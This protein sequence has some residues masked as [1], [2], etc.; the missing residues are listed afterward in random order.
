LTGK[1][2]RIG[3]VPSLVQEQKGDNQQTVR[4]LANP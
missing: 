2:C 1:K 3:I 4:S